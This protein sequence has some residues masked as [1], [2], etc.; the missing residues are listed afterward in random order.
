MSDA[1][2]QRHVEPHLFVIFG[3]TGDLA[4]RKIAPAL[5]R[6]RAGGL[7][8]E[9]TAVLGI[10]RDAEM[11]DESYRAL[12]ETALADAGID[13]ETRRSWCEKCLHYQPIR[14]G[15]PEDY[16][17]LTARIVDVERAHGLGGNRILYLA[18]PPAVFPQTIEALGE[19]GLDE[20]LGWTR[21][22]IE[23]PFGRDLNSAHALNQLVHRWFDESQ[24]YRIDHYLGKETVQNLL[25]FRFANPI[26]ESVWNRDR[27]E[28]VHITVAETIGVGSRAGYYDRAGALRDMVQNHLTQL[29]TL[30]AMEGPAAFRADDIRTEKIKV[31]RAIEPISPDDAVFGQYTAGAADGEEMAGYRDE[32]GVADTSPTPTYAAIALR[33]GNWRWQGVPF[34]LRTGKRLAER[35]T[36][37]V[38]AFREPPVALFGT[39]A[40]CRTPRSNRLAITLQPN[41]GFE[42]RF[43]VKTPGPGID[44]TTQRLRFAYAEAFGRLPEAYET[45][46]LDVAEG[47]PTL[48]VH[49]DEVE[50]SWQLYEPLLDRDVMPEPYPA[51][52]WGPAAAEA[53]VHGDGEGW[54]RRS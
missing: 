15:T 43:E 40:G 44:V 38:V 20:G 12:I 11:N 39:Q 28:S 36:R 25:V 18:L 41:E 23:K 29:L 52:S 27:V 54:E 4:R 8:P 35:L 10:A 5:V 30:V 48:F 42:L 13:E 24:V 46:L 1:H 7:L 31:L 2:E 9:P 34:F 26:F 45:L 53:L 14:D 32:H 50:A 49:A 21:L 3:G 37:I 17:A 33:I 16:R 51:G 47:D 19:C 6:L 22:V